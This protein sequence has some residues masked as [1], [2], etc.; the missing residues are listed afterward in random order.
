[1]E[2]FHP[3]RTFTLVER[4]RSVFPL[5]VAPVSDRS[6]LDNGKHRQHSFSI[7]QLNAQI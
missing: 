7:D 4:C 3:L 1:M 6:A 2:T 5:T